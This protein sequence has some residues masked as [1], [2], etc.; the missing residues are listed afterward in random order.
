MSKDQIVKP[1]ATT[2]VAA[3]AANTTRAMQSRISLPSH[4]ETLTE[5]SLRA[6]DEAHFICNDDTEVR[7][8]FPLT[9]D[10]LIIWLIPRGSSVSL[11]T[12]YLSCLG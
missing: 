4:A 12:T 8:L 2:A 5:T 3:A 9:A 6:L 7:T 1:V 10:S 11:W